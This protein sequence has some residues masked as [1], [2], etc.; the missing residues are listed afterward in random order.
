MCYVYQNLFSKFLCFDLHKAGFHSLHETLLVA[1][2]NTST[3]NGVFVPVCVYAGIDH[4]PK[5]IIHNVS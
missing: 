1:E 5:E 3:S 4:T 2:S